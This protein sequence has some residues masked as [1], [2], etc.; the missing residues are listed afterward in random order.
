MIRS[1]SSLD[2]KGNKE[3]ITF[4]HGR[5]VTSE[6]AIAEHFECGCQAY[7]DVFTYAMWKKQGKQ[8]SKGEK[9]FKLQTFKVSEYE[10]KDGE[11]VKKIYPKTAVVFCRCQVK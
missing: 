8:V 11:T 4:E 2:I 10:N 5:S 1:C 7:E 3:M 9:G 6:A